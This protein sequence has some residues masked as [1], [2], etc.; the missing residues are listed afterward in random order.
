M[1]CYI[2]MYMNYHHSHEGAPQLM[3]GFSNEDDAKEYMEG[4]NT[5]AEDQYYILEIPFD[6]ISGDENYTW[7]HNY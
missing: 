6:T 1:S 7:A 4:Y 5:G 2:V 3:A